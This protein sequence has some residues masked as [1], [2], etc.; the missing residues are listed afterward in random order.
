MKNVFVI[1]AS[2]ACLCAILM[3]TFTGWIRGESPRDMSGLQWVLPAHHFARAFLAFAFFSHV[4]WLAWIHGTWKR[5]HELLHPSDEPSPTK[6]VLMLIT[7]I[8]NVLWQFTVVVGACSVV[9]DALAK[10]IG[11]R[12]A[13]T[14]LAIVWCLFASWGWAFLPFLQSAWLTIVVPLVGFFLMRGVD[15]ALGELDQND[16][17]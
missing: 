11:K 8:L 12:R 15:A 3:S 4:A 17:A 16:I 7:P 9:N 6:A 1:L 14:G 5:I 2:T 10:K 13:P